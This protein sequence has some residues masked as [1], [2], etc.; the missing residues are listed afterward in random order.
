MPEFN[1]RPENYVVTF[2]GSPD[3]AKETLN[4]WRKEH[5]HSAKELFQITRTTPERIELTATPAMAKRLTETKL[6]GIDSVQSEFS[7]QRQGR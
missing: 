7:L 5:C 2:S 1:G 6:E 3:N 4:N